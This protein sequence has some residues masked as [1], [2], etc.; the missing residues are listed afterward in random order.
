M[1]YMHMVGSMRCVWLEAGERTP[2]G[3]SSC[4]CQVCE[5]SSLAT[6]HSYIF[7]LFLGGIGIYIQTKEINL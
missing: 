4:C 1:G 3:I 7:P 2:A 6:S 5:G